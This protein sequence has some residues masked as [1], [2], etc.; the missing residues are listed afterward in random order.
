M[1]TRRRRLDAELVERTLARSRGEA[2]ELIAAGRVLVE[3]LVATKPSRQV[4]AGASVR[5]DRERSTRFVSR[6]A[7]KLAG[8]LTEFG[9]LAVVGAKA[10][11]AGASTGGFTQVLLAAGA[12]HVVA[13]DVGYGQL[14]WTLQTDSRVTV[15]DRTNVRDL[16]AVDLPYAPTLIVGDL[17][18]ISLRTVLPAL[19]SVA[20]ISGDMVLLVKPQFEVGRTK[21]GKRGVVRGRDDRAQAVRDVAETAWGLGLGVAGVTASKLPG[22]AGN[23]EFFLWLRRD[24]AQLRDH[25]LAAAI[26]EGPA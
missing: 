7:G 6:G 19:A 18:F 26:M 21:I 9:S 23:V 2:H 8:A 15:R 3:G 4:D 13:V 10:L 24:Q 22:P 25:E 14:A 11:D 17:S 12:Q 20:D 1:V 16:A 5:V